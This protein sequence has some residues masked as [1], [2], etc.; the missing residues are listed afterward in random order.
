M[1]S[2]QTSLARTISRRVLP[3]GK[4]RDDFLLH[5]QP[6]RKLIFEP[7]EC[8]LALSVSGAVDGPPPD[9]YI[10]VF[11]D[12]VADPAGETA[13]LL[14]EHH[15]QLRHVYRHVLNGFS[16]KLPPPAVAAL[17]ESP[18]VKY[19]E[20][21]GRA[22]ILAQELPPGIDRVDSDLNTVA[23]ID[24]TDQRVNVN[25]A[26]IDTGIDLDHPDLNVVGGI[27]TL[28]NYSPDDYD[29]DD[30]HG[31]HVAGIAAAL[32]NGF[33]V[34]GVAPGANLWAVKVLDQKGSGS[35]EGILAG[36]DWVTETR[37]DADL[38]NDIDV[39][40][41]SLVMFGS[42]DL[43]EEAVNRMTDAGI[44][45]VA[46]AGNYG[47]GGGAIR[48]ANFARA[49]AVSATVETDGKPGG[50]GPSTRDGDDD[51][52]AEFSNY[53]GK[54]ELAAPGVDV[55]STWKGGRYKSISGTS[56][57]S[58]HVAGAAALF[59]AEHTPSDGSFGDV[60][61]VE[62]VRQALIG[63][64][65]PRDQW[66]VDYA[67]DPRDHKA[68]M[69][70]VSD[71]WVTPPVASIL[72]PVQDA[73]LSGAVAIQV[74][75]RDVDTVQ[76][77]LTVSIE[78]DGQPS[79]TAAFN[80]D[81][82]YYEFDWNTVGL[83]GL[84]QIIAVATDS[85]NNAS[86]TTS[87][88]VANDVTVVVNNVD[89]P[90]IVDVVNPTDG[91]TV[92]GT[93]VLEAHAADDNDISAVDFV[94]DPNLGPLPSFVTEVNPGV[95]ATD[96][97]T[98]LFPLGT[99]SVTAIAT[100]TGGN[101]SHN[102]VSNI[103]VDNSLPPNTMHVAD[104]D[105]TSSLI[106]KSGAWRAYVDVAIV[107]TNGTPVSS[108]TVTGD[109]GGVSRAEVTALTDA[110]GVV[111][112]AEK[113]ESHENSSVTLT[114]IDVAH[115]SLVYQ[116]LANTDPDGD[117]D[118][119]TI[120]VY[121]DSLGSSSDQDGRELLLSIAVAAATG[122][123]RMSPLEMPAQN[124]AVGTEHGHDPAPAVYREIEWADTLSRPDTFGSAVD[125]VMA[126]AQE[127]PVATGET[128]L[129]AVLPAWNK[130]PFGLL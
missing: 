89:D 51:T 114:V 54:I 4:I 98:T 106:G 102:T 116:R 103:L 10:V 92:N 126:I 79:S 73:V 29:D 121:R 69:V 95:W 40:N 60:L 5:R 16:A 32:D 1:C 77:E 38:E 75:A 19:I 17:Q 18:Q 11:H 50:L 117:S 127:V 24:G 129:T 115:S 25:I 71:G 113:I 108:A 61:D 36:M 58:P 2:A 39:A 55:F 70:N 122:D 37:L 72:S 82:G 30:G 76:G 34:V 84:H 87:A 107:N 15:G 119:T 43:I 120:T 110:S 53:G 86:S 63:S 68:P 13:D 28:D 83:D 93:V 78:I 6:S 88:L 35:T 104:L 118:G 27:N 8:R 123:S 85:S 45:L 7:L 52:F 59:I 48:P 128:A 91:S 49:L 67:I 9:T 3:F 57:A 56:M 105:Q 41:M 44:V 46:A 101:S 64:G 97:D 26:I 100:D 81:S 62:L 96:W 66:D 90:P 99:Y 14:K 20:P 23:N 22:E 124:R 31:S 111:S 65:Q 109:W 21:N 94:I 12:D 130:D 42:T 33:G 47:F 125:Q 80:P 74:D 112:F